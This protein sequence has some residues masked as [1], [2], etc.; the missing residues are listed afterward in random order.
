MPPVKVYSQE[1]VIEIEENNIYVNIDDILTTPAFMRRKVK[2]IKDSAE[3]VPKGA[4][5]SL[6]DEVAQPESPK[7][8]ANLFD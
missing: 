4:K 6:K 7:P 2:F 3:G 8:S 5:V 1:Q